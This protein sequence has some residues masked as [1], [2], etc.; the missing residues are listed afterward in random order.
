M[1]G[2]QKEHL[3]KVSQLYEYVVNKSLELGAT[4]VFWT[5][6]LCSASSRTNH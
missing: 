1:M 4:D 6:S 3:V 2:G 5:F